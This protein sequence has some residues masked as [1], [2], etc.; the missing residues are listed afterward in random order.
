[1]LLFIKIISTIV[2]AIYITLWVV[3]VFRTEE[4][5]EQVVSVIF[6]LLTVL[7]ICSIWLKQK[8]VVKM[9]FKGYVPTKNK[10]CTMS[11]KGK[12][13]EELL[14]FEE[15][16][17]FDEYAGILNDDAMLIDIDDYDHDG[18]LKY[19]RPIP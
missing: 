14:T 6:A 16:Q 12:S 17:K 19:G 7:I 18:N 2:T 15:A 1:M 9:F 3:N 5:K 13:S 10:K 4:T 11:F 8:A